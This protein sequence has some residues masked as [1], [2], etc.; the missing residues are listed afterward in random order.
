M[1]R[2][3]LEHQKCLEEELKLYIPR[4]MQVQEHKKEKAYLT[5]NGIKDFVSVEYGIQIFVHFTC[6]NS[7]ES[8]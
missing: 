3:L 5:W 4:F 7:C 1:C 8:N 6:R 2:I